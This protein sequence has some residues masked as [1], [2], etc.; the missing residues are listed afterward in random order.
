MSIQINAAIVVFLSTWFTTS[1]DAQEVVHS[2]SYTGEYL[3]STD[4]D[5][6]MQLVLNQSGGG[7]ATQVC[8]AEDG[9]HKKYTAKFPL[10]WNAERNLIYIRHSGAL[11]I[12]SYETSMSC[13]SSEGKEG[14]GLVLKSTEKNILNGYGDKFWKKGGGC[15]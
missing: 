10:A 9:T 12:L 13:D 7:T 5:C 15:I 1:C 11:I 8:V 3:T 6:D 14:V 4:A 2:A